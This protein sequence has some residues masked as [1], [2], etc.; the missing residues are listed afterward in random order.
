M[1]S[2]IGREEI[3]ARNRNLRLEESGLS[4]FMGL[5]IPNKVPKVGG[6]ATASV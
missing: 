5:S 6:I 3:P 2:K 4:G 1:S